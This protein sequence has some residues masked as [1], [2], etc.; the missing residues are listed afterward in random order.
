VMLEIALIFAATIEHH[1]F[2]AGFSVAAE[3]FMLWSTWWAVKRYRALKS[4]FAGA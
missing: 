3:L 2:I 1:S 4:Q